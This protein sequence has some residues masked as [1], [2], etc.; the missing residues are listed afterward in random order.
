MNSFL[1]GA[2]PY[3][4]LALSLILLFTPLSSYASLVLPS[5]TH[6]QT[7]TFT[8]S[9]EALTNWVD[10]T[11]ATYYPQEKIQHRD[12]LAKLYQQANFNNFWFDT[13]GHPNTA[14]RLLLNDL[15]PW[16]ALD[17]HPKLNAYQQLAEL[18]QYP[19]NSNL[20]RQRQAADLRVTDLFLSYQDD[21]LQG[22]WT[23][24][25]S[26]QDHG[27]TNAYERW[28][29]WPD[30]VVRRRLD[31]V[32]PIWLQALQGQ[33]PAVWLVNVI[34]E[35]QPI[36][37]YY[38]PWRKAFSELEEMASLGD[39]PKVT[40]ELSLGVRAVDVTRL[41][42]QLSR[43][44]DLD[45][46]Q[47]YLPNGHLPEGYVA[48]GYPESPFNRPEPLFDQKLE[49]ALKRFQQR[50]QLKTTGITDDKTRAWLNMPPEE[51]MRLLAHNIRRLHH[52]P[53]QLNQRH[54]MV[55]MAD[56]RLTFVEQQQLKLDM[57]IVIG[58]DGLRTPIVNQWLTSIV[59]N[60]LWNVPTSIAKSTILP[61]AL[62]NPN[63][64]SS[65]DYALVNGWHTP[66]RFVAL[67]QL[68]ADAFDNEKS[69]YRIVQKTGN[70]NQLGKAKFRLSNQQAIYLHDTPYRHVFNA[71]NRDLSSGCVRLEG[72]DQLA[73]A[74]LNSDND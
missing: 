10:S 26:D 41:A 70:H 62:Q 15:K 17:S 40:A 55:N 44:G 37:S 4:S 3:P 54:I 7:I 9:H 12:Y 20:P 43:Q 21:L 64:L 23:Q 32:F 5:T 6:Q 38:L 60:P 66:S 57:K 67:D 74:V 35:T 33:T 65:R 42:A 27:I 13:K 59:L 30:E 61:R 52:L 18:L 11:L 16:L 34:Q 49:Q 24:F 73:L 58:R 8:T 69:G 72:A 56:Q 2:T 36:G 51:R 50:H 25:D 46:L 68:P 28:D 14:A 47:P 1:N 29:N 45:N 63:Y 19:V 48:E 53:K 31:E 39:W 22:F 71:D